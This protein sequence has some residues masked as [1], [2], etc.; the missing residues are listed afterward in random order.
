LTGAGSAAPAVRQTPVEPKQQNGFLA[1]GKHSSGQ[2]RRGARNFV[3]AT[4]EAAGQFPG[5]KNL[6][7]QN[8]PVF[9]GD[10]NLSGHRPPRPIGPV[11]SSVGPM[12][13]RVAF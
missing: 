4:P 7:G 13:H 5:D 9:P 11:A 8:R 2:N 3:T 10:K 1:G 12:P 6:S